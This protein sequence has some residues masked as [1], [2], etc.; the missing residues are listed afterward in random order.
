MWR[1][2][3]TDSLRGFASH[4]LGRQPA[5]RS[6]GLPAEMTPHAPG[7]LLTRHAPGQAAEL[8]REGGGPGR[9]EAASPAV[10]QGVVV[11]EELPVAEHRVP[12]EEERDRRLERPEARVVDG[13]PFVAVV[14]GAEDD[15]VFLVRRLREPP[16]DV[17]EERS[18]TLGREIGEDDDDGLVNRVVVLGRRLL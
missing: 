8:L 2:A 5:C 11:H 18:G 6:S 3:A 14:E 4:R 15:P 9:S 10:E 17:G 7:E 13:C 1:A 16:E 12:H